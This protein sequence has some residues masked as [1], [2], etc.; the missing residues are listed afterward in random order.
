[1]VGLLLVTIALIVSP[2]AA[3]AGGGPRDVALVIN[4]N[5]YA[6]QEIGRYYQ[7]VRGIP[8]SNICWISCPDQEV[9]S[10]TVCE[11]DIRAPIHRFLASPA[12]CGKI[13]YIVLTK[14]VPL[15]ADY[16]DSTGPYSVGSIL[17]CVDNPEIKDPLAFPY[18]P[19]A[20]LVWGQPAP[21]IA[22]SHSL[23]F[24]GYHFYL[25]TRL[26]AFT[27]SQVK[28]LIDRGAASTA[29]GK[30]VLD[31]NTWTTGAYKAAND[32]L[33]D[34]MGSAYAALTAAGQ[35]VDYDPGDTFLAGE[36]GVMGYFS[37]AGLDDQYSFAKYVSN[38]FLPGSIA[39]TYYS[40]SAR[41]FIAPAT[42]NR[43]PLI[44]D[45]I[46][47][48]LCGCA[49]YV[50]EPYVSTA[51]Y[52]NVLF[53]RYIKGFNM[54]ESFYAGCPEVFWKTVVVGDPLMAPYATPP[55]VS[56]TVPNATLTGAVAVSANAADPH[57]ISQVKIYFDDDLIGTLYSP[58]YTVMLDTT[59]Y[60]IGAHTIEAIAYQAS[61][62]A[63][64]G[65]A[66]M[67]VIV[68]NPV[69]AVRHINDAL[70]YPDGQYVRVRDKVVTANSAEIGDGFYMEEPDRS[71]GI[72]VLSDQVVNRGDVVMVTGGVLTVNGERVISDAEIAV[73][74]KG[75]VVPGPLLMKQRDLGGAGI[76][77]FTAKV[78]Q[79]RGPHNIGLLVRIW[80]YVTSIESGSFYISDKS[81][82]VP[83]VKVYCPGLNNLSPGRLA[84]VTG[85]SSVDFDGTIIRP[86]IRARNSDD[87]QTFN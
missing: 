84:A 58:P 52:A 23:D 59:N 16:G 38:Q 64:Q 79:A 85:I 6:S 76:G 81:P 83:P 86:C 2:D 71:S 43:Q 41:T 18:G 10:A 32:R 66:H 53:D 8:E 1:M 87:I 37:W 14:G 63:T 80:G 20:S 48:G 4:C 5:S 68:D 25:V 51:T 42:T 34:Q 46:P 33:G 82:K 74:S 21:E 17:T 54:A 69:S 56:I 15:M 36:Q 73:E 47:C 60:P 28:A 67:Q 78:G 7:A 65:S 29:S 39:D 11:D 13:D 19:R 22:W 72:K 27:V 31:R 45:L 77:A 62:P 57:G 61:N 24:N 70:C 49:G 30:F 26:D 44:A 75:A 12:V 35:K 40:Y 9:V 55:K 50:S 3:Y